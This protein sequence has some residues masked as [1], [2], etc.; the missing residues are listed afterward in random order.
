MGLPPS[1]RHGGQE[2]P[3]LGASLSVQATPS[4]TH[5]PVGC[6]VRDS[7]DRPSESAW[8][9]SFSPGLRLTIPALRFLSTRQKVWGVLSPLLGMVRQ[10]SVIPKAMYACPSLARRYVRNVCW[11]PGAPEARFA[12]WL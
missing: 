1:S 10:M 3:T 9:N 5:D 8:T 2:F 12:E 6:A 7:R 11:C 4:S